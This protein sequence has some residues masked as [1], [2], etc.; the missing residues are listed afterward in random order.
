MTIRNALLLVAVAFFVIAF[1]VM[2]DG[3]SGYTSSDNV[4]FDCVD[5]SGVGQDVSQ[6]AHLLFAGLAIVSAALL[7]HDALLGRRPRGSG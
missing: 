3:C 1:V 7:D 6:A 5:P 2:G 4:T